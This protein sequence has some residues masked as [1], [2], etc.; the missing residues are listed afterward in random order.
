VSQQL[1]SV[2]HPANPRRLQPPQ[3]GSPLASSLHSPLSW[4]HGIGKLFA[5]AHRSPRSAQPPQK[6]FMQGTAGQHSFPIGHS[7]PRQDV[8]VPEQFVE[9][10][11]ACKVHVA[12]SGL[13]Q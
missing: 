7:R 4:Q 10:H 2:L 8:Q 12:P 5:V 11:E 6:P 1:N 3:N 9:Q 13:Q